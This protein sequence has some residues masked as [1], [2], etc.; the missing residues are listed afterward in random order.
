[1][2]PKL[3]CWQAPAAFADRR[4][5]GRALAQRLSGYVGRAD[6]IVLALPRGGVPVAYEVARTLVAPLDVFVVRKLGVPLQEELAM[7]AIASGGMCVLN[8]AEIA[9]LA[10]SEAEFETVMR[11]ERRE[12]ERRERAY[13]GSR[14]PAPVLDR[15]VIL[16]DDGIATGAS[17]RVAVA[18][19]RAHGPSRIVVAAPV[20]AR[21]VCRLLEAEADAFVCALAP[22]PFVGVGRWYDD[23]S[24]LTDRD[25]RGLLAQAHRV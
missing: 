7:G 14:A 20:A 11:R 12:L 2:E 16:V 5:A 24:Q 9:A 3:I 4:E 15:T 25:V 19:L 23:F 1:M 18:A 21:D 13:R 17:M 10:L 6:V 8:T 22:Q